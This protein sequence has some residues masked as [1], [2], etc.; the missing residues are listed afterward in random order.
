MIGLFDRNDFRPTVGRAEDN[1]EWDDKITSLGLTKIP[2][3]AFAEMFGQHG[4]T[5]SWALEEAS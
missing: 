5:F 3:S 1:G 4:L 2:L